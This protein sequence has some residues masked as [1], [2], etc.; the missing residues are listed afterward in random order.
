MTTNK[1]L[2][3]QLEERGVQLERKIQ[4]LNA[5]LDTI[6]RTVELLFS[7]K[8]QAE[9]I[10]ECKEA[11]MLIVETKKDKEWT[12][13]E[14]LAQMKKMRK[15]GKMK[16]KS[17]NLIWSIYAAVNTLVKEKKLVKI[18]V[19]RGRRVRLKHPQDDY[20]T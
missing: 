5:D 14:I 17:K 20:L 15:E 8:R 9:E 3:G 19:G 18:G 4:Q 7:D 6:L 16:S 2:I 1:S 13:V 11:T 10:P 12:T